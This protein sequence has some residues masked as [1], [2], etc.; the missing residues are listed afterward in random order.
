LWLFSTISSGLKQKRLTQTLQSV[1][2]RNGQTILLSVSSLPNKDI[3]I[4]NPLSHLVIYRIPIAVFQHCPC[5]YL[6]TTILRASS[7]N[8]FPG[9][10]AQPA[11]L[12]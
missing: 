6:S 10:D 11:G 5:V 4:P 3:K 8:I 9:K 2:N 7:V 1:D 12:V